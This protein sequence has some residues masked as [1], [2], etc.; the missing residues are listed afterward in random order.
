MP[1]VEVPKFVQR[2][3]DAGPSYV[4]EQQVAKTRVL[5]G[6]HGMH[7]DFDPGDR[8][9]PQRQGDVLQA[10]LSMSKKARV[11]KSKKVRHAEEAAEKINF[12]HC[13]GQPWTPTRQNCHKCCKPTPHISGTSRFVCQMPRSLPQRTGYRDMYSLRMLS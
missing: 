4:F 13:H 1:Q 9:P 7:A 6:E 12:G 8:R 2:E 10:E 5:A 3:R 11:E